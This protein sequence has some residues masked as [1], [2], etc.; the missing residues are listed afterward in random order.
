MEKAIRK[1]KQRLKTLR[2]K[3]LNNFF[4]AIALLVGLI[5]P[6]VI[7][8]YNDMRIGIQNDS[9]GMEWKGNPIELI[10]PSSEVVC[11]IRDKIFPNK[12][13]NYTIEDIDSVMDYVNSHIK[14]SEDWFNWNASDYFATPE[15][16]IEKGLGDCEDVAIL[17]CSI[18]RS[19]GLDAWVVIGYGHA[20]VRIFDGD[21]P[22]DYFSIGNRPEYYMF[23]DKRIVSLD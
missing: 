4:I 21:E 14:Y 5:G 17:T 12:K 6:F 9:T 13:S 1:I 10:N 7:E 3:K 18:L 11:D 20:W 23:N 22:F 2:G 15:E 8:Q 16:T 19:M